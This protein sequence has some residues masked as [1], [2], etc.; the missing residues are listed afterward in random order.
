VF[1]PSTWDQVLSLPTDASE[2]NKFFVDA[3]NGDIRPTVLIRRMRGIVSST[4][5]DIV[6]R[7]QQEHLL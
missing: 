7:R 5:S 6:P 2:F 4:M 3:V 1:R